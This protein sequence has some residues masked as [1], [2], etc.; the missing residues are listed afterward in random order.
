MI[1]KEVFLIPSIL[2][3]CRRIIS[4]SELVE[5]CLRVVN[6]NN[7]LVENLITKGYMK[8]SPFFIPYTITNMGSALLAIDH[9]FMGPNYSIVAACATANY[10]FYA[11]ANHI[12][13]GEADLMVAG[14]A[15]AAIIPVG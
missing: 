11:A 15:E 13:K 8:L 4:Q 7:G 1:R 12:R 2:R 9:G 10:A 5:F 14:G 6:V 3:E